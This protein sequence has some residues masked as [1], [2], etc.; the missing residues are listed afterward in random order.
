[1][2]VHKYFYHLWYLQIFH[3]LYMF[4]KELFYKVF[5]VRCCP[6][7][8]FTQTTAKN[9]NSAITAR[10]VNQD[11]HTYTKLL[12]DLYG[13]SNYKIEANV[14]YNQNG[15]T[16]KIAKVVNKHNAATIYGYFLEEVNNSKLYY[17]TDN[18]VTKEI[19]RYSTEVL[20]KYSSQTYNVKNDTFYITYGLNPDKASKAGPRFWGWGSGNEACI[21]GVQVVYNQY[22]IFG[23]PVNDRVYSYDNNG[24]VITVPC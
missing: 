20:D 14:T 23:I 13:A 6:H 4:H 24:E 3:L 8:W 9:E 1:M 2:C 5:F 10:S 12:K 16:Y 11:F 22:Y 17:I 21:D 18:A 19:T 7:L 15:L